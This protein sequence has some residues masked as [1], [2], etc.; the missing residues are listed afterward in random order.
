MPLL[1][2]AVVASDWLKHESDKY[3]SRSTG[4]LASGQGKLKSGTVLGRLT[5]SG[6]YVVAA[7]SGSD[8]SQTATAILL[9]SADA[10]SADAQIVVVDT[11][12]DVSHNGL[13]W[14]STINDATKRAAA[15]A[16]LATKG[17][18]TREGA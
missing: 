1:E 16:Q 3:H 9:L 12:A 15:I 7:A 2:T 14:G 11:H 17:I 5:A 8:G 18:K 13:T 10:T 6:K 4:L